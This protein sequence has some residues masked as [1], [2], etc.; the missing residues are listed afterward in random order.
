MRHVIPETTGLV[1]IFLRKSLHPLHTLI[2]ALPA[3]AQYVQYQS[4]SSG[5]TFNL[6]LC[7]DIFALAGTA[8]YTALVNIDSATPALTRCPSSRALYY[9][10]RSARATFI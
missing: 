3:Q 1:F 5:D 7:T 4:F 10:V 9:T 8:Q 6:R 2:G